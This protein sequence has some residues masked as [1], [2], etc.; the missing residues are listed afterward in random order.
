[1]RSKEAYINKCIPDLPGAAKMNWFLWS[2]W[3]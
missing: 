3:S 1:V 2:F